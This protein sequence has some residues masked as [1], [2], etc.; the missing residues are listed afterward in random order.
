M[1][2]TQGPQPTHEGAY[3]GADGGG[4]SANGWAGKLG[5]QR[6]AI[7]Q[8]F[9]DQTHY[10][11]LDAAVP[12]QDFLAIPPAG[13]SKGTVNQ[14]GELIHKV[15]LPD[16]PSLSGYPF[17]FGLLFRSG[18]PAATDDDLDGGWNYTFIDRVVVDYEGSEPTG[19]TWTSSTGDVRT[20][21]ILE[22]SNGTWFSV[23]RGFSRFRWWMDGQT[24]RLERYRPDGSVMR[25]ERVP[26]SNRW[27]PSVFYDPYDNAWTYA[28]TQYGLIDKV[29]DPRG[30]EVRFVRS[31]GM[32]TV[33]YWA[34][35]QHASALDHILTLATNGLIASVQ[36]ATTSY[37]QT[38]N[39]DLYID[40]SR[41]RG[42]SRRK[43]CG[44]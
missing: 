22:S 41:P 28:W 7:G 20:G 38:K 16:P 10:Q 1:A 25:Y 4:C 13:N 29:T 14:V 26:N 5:A 21:S 35:G 33:E 11:V 27:R 24:E 31:T 40:V 37:L 43:A 2:Q 3:P 34:N 23:D 36:Q 6:V 9:E 44:Q 15:E 42:M 8:G 32:V 19:L 39:G 30:I 18:A 12:A 17:D